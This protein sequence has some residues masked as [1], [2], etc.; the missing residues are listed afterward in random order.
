MCCD[1]RL[2]KTYC[3]I[4]HL[5]EYMRYPNLKSLAVFDAAARHLNFRRAA[6]ELHLTQGAVAQQVRNLEA[7]LSHV[8]FVRK[9]RGLELTTTGLHY[10]QAVQRALRIVRQATDELLPDAQ[11]V[12]LS[13]TPS[14]ASKW[15]VPRLA[16]FA[17]QHPEIDLQILADERLSDFG[18][19]GVD[20]V[21]RF[22]QEGLGSKVVMQHLADLKLTVVC[23][24]EY[25]TKLDANIS[26]ADFANYKLIQDSH[27][28]FWRQ[29]F[30]FHGVSALPRML[31]FNQTAL[32]IDAAINGQGLALSPFML[33]QNDIDKGNLVLLWQDESEQQEA[34]YLAY[35]KSNEKNTAR[36][37]VLQW[38]CDEVKIV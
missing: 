38:I 21:I 22:G 10:H 5:P 28:Q 13:A 25:A 37:A 4:Q 33:V 7:E 2:Q 16:P 6:D 24:P 15:V 14:F 30:E 35:A 29:L 11:R 32:A 9:A 3:L 31:H 1:V 20:I 18:S 36:E 26:F 23:N 12:V 19:G 34:Y 8:L 27:P 17:E